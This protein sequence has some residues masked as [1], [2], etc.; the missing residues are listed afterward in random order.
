VAKVGL[1]LYVYAIARAKS[2]ALGYDPGTGAV[3]T[4]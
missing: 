1:G 3:A 2:D 4:A